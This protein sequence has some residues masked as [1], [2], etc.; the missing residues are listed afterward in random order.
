MAGGAMQNPG[1]RATQV[2]DELL[3]RM[4]TALV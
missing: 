2:D 1:S 4:A 3:Q